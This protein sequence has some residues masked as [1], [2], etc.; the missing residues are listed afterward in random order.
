MVRATGPRR[1]AYVCVPEVVKTGV[2]VYKVP[3][4]FMKYDFEFFYDL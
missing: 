4:H 1:P 2:L 3:R